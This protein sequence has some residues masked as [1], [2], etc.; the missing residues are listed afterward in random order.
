MAIAHLHR[1]C[2]ALVGIALLSGGCAATTNLSNMWKDP[3]FKSGPMNEVLVMAIDSSLGFRRNLE[4][5]LV[6]AIT[7]GKTRALAWYTVGST[8]RPV[9]QKMIEAAVEE[10]G[11]DGVLVARFLGQKEV[12]TYVPGYVQTA[13][14]PYYAA[15]YSMMY[16]DW[17]TVYQSGYVRTDT[18]TRMQFMLY[19]PK[20]KVVWTGTSATFNPASTKELRKSVIRRVIDELAKAGLIH[21]PAG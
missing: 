6:T 21:E 2:L 17:R 10:T 14:A 13:P 15:P 1:T 12:E 19:S 3:Q 8:A 11:V 20:G 18:V 5:G 9:D 7:E 16:A 4:D